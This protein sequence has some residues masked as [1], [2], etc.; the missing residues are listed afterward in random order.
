MYYAINPNTGHYHLL[1][2]REGGAGFMKAAFVEMM[3]QPS[4]W[5]PLPIDVAISY[6]QYQAMIKPPHWYKTAG[7]W[8][9][10]LGVTAGSFL[11][12]KGFKKS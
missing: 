11:L 12:V 9:V 2:E 3:E 8:G 4:D 5:K 1:R 10:L 6:E 7:G